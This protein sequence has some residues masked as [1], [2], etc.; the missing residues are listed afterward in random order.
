VNKPVINDLSNEIKLCERWY[1]YSRA[2]EV[3]DVEDITKVHLI[4]D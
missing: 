2:L 1:A 4:R 3:R